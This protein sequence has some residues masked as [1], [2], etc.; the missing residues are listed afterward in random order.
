LIQHEK[1]EAGRPPLFSCLLFVG[2]LSLKCR[3]GQAHGVA[4]AEADL[5]CEL[6][7][8]LMLLLAHSEAGSQDLAVRLLG[9]WHV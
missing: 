9:S 3:E 6:V 5:V 8:L 1:G 4:E 2:V 7:E